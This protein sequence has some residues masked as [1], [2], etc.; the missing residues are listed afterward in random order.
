MIKSCP[1]RRLA[2]KNLVILTSSIKNKGSISIKDCYTGMLSKLV[3]MI[4][5]IVCGVVCKVRDW[6]SAKFI[7]GKITY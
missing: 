7:A 3:S 5:E 1:C 4:M 2:S 6:Q